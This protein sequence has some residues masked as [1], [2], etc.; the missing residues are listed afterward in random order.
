MI[1]DGDGD[2]DHDG[3]KNFSVNVTSL[4]HLDYIL[5]SQ[6]PLDGPDL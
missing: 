5:Q 6:P 2:G 3:D 4:L 1:D